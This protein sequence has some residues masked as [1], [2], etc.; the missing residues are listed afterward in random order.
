VTK[1]RYEG[2]EP[3]VHARAQALARYAYLLVYDA[4]LAED[5]VQQ[6]MTE[7]ANR[8]PRLRDGNPEAYARKVILNAAAGRARRRKVVREDTTDAVPDTASIADA[9]ADLDLQLA[10]DAV[11]AGLPPRQRAVLVL[12]FYEDLSEA[13]TAA[14]LRV[15]IGTVK[16]QTHHAL[17]R[18]R[19]FAPDLLDPTNEVSP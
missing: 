7:L 8:W 15:S 11:L 18:L 9:A 14:Q 4:Q 13:E 12:R 10:L 17:S 3:F 2:F 1:D 6:A 16:S 5:L 19:A